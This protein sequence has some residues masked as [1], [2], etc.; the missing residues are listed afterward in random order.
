MI[1]RWHSYTEHMDTEKNTTDSK[2]RQTGSTPV[3]DRQNYPAPV[4]VKAHQ[5]VMRER[6]ALVPE[7]NEHRK[8]QLASSLTNAVVHEIDHATAKTVILKYEWLKNM[9]TTEFSFGLFF[10]E[11][12]A[13]VVCF[14]RT[15]GSNVTSSVAGESNAQRVI[16]LCRGACKHWAHEHSASFLISAAC[17]LMVAKGY[18]V[19]VSYADPEAGEIGTVYQST[20]WLYC[21][22]TNPTLKFRTPDGIV[23]DSRLVHCYTRDRRGGRLAYRRTRDEQM[24][25]MKEQG[26]VFFLGGSKYRYVSIRGN[27]RTVRTLRKALA[28]KVMPYPKRASLKATVVEPPRQTRFDPASP[29]QQSLGVSLPRVAPNE[30]STT[31]AKAK[32][33]TRGRSAIV[34]VSVAQY[35]GRKCWFL[36]HAAKYF[37]I[38]PCQTLIEPFAGSGLVGLSLLHAGI[39]DRLVLVEKDERMICLLEGLLDDPTLADRYVAF[40]CT[41]ANVKG[42]LRSEKSAF[43]YLVQSRC[44]NR[45]KFDGGLRTVIDERWCRDMVV[46]NIRRVYALRD[47]ITVVESDGLEVMRQYS[48]DPNVG[49]FAD[50]PYSADAISKGHT[51]YRHHKLNHQKLFSILAGWRGPWLLTEDNSPMVRSL[52]LCYR[53]RSKRV[54]MNT[55]DNRKTTELVLRRR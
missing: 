27:R 45:A 40:S 39:I 23:K 11:Y 18:N 36:R 50:P 38:H 16:T 24:K 44:S 19:F 4:S 47:R 54:E 25:L 35:P 34:A 55:S 28:W 37:R 7:E 8:R 5:R 21:G 14:G 1:R 51:M 43:R 46:R 52:A 42:L 22:T 17:D 53:F 31:E 41:T 12:L 32:R 48:D 29:L 10:G 15:A 30:G 33:S 3:F 20:N 13:G 49:C 26:N 6:A 9:G 2:Q